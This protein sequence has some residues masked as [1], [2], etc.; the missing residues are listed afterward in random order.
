LL[1][2]V[3]CAPAGQ[4]P[5]ELILYAYPTAET[6]TTTFDGF[7]ADLPVGDC[8]SGNAR[9]TWSS[10]GVTQGPLACYQSTSGQ[11]TVIWGSES[12][13]VLVVASDPVWS[14]STMYAWWQEDAP[15]LQ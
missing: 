1:A 11:T 9:A 10:D 14:A 6:M 5:E 3:V 4:E 13:G 7:A 2:V 12:K 15:Y 8:S